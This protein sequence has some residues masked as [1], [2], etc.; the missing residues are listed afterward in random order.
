MAPR[1]SVCI[2]I[3]GTFT[4][5]VV[6]GERGLEIYKTAS[7]PPAFERGFMES[8]SLAADELEPDLG[9]FLKATG[10]LAKI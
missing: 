7:T 9:A 5:C 10:I 6:A 1:Y 4:D 2:D 8:L 3:G